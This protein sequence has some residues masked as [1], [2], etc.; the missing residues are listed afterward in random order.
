MG[1]QIVSMSSEEVSLQTLN[2]HAPFEIKPGTLILDEHIFSLEFSMQI[3]QIISSIIYVTT[4]RQHSFFCPLLVSVLKSLTLEQQCL[5]YLGFS[6]HYLM[7]F[8]S[9]LCLHTLRTF[10]RLKTELI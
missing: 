5:M 9:R 3:S 1:F 10:K 7:R 2:Q 4:G 8:T 6:L